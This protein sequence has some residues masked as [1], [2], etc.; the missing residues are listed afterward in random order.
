MLAFATVEAVAFAIA[1]AGA[2][3]DADKDEA[4]EE[5]ISMLISERELEDE[6]GAEAVAQWLALL[7]LLSELPFAEEEELPTS[8][9]GELEVAAEPAAGE[10]TGFAE[11][12]VAVAA[13]EAEVEGVGDEDAARAGDEGGV[14]R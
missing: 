7:S 5:L 12:A 2:V 1:A 11:A 6:D 14:G 8:C 3:A 13:F 4:V 9:E 10:T